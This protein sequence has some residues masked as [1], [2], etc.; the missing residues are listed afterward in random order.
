MDAEYVV[1]RNGVTGFVFCVIAETWQGWTKTGATKRDTLL[2]TN[3]T[4]EQAQQFCKLTY[5]ED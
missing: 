1:Y 5:E 4:R 3:L 2:A